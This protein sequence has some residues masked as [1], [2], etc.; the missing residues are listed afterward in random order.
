M[1]GNVAYIF[2]AAYVRDEDRGGVT[3][4]L[5]WLMLVTR[6]IERTSQSPGRTQFL[7]WIKHYCK[8]LLSPKLRHF[9]SKKKKKKR[10]VLARDTG[11]P[12]QCCTGHRSTVKG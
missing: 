7:K 5:V 2:A 10:A 4:F 1:A 8:D 9:S 3:R 12:L 11:K 6:Q